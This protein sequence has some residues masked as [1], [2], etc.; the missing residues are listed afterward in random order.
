MSL[1]GVLSLGLFIRRLGRARSG[2]G[3]PFLG[4]IEPGSDKRLG[5]ADGS[6]L[7]KRRD[8]VHVLGQLRLDSLS[9]GNIKLAEGQGDV[10]NIFTF[11]GAR[12][13]KVKI[14]TTSPVIM[15][16]GVE[17]SGF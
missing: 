2:D 13:T 1:L 11:G 17:A 14:L 16:G 7:Q 6:R 8:L 12:R 9:L 5:I 10:V 3:P 15:A 4:E